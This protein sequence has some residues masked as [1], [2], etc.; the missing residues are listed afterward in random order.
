MSEGAED[1][2]AAGAV[3]LEDV[4]G[5]AGRV[6][7]VAAA[8]GGVT[9][10]GRRRGARVVLAPLVISGELVGE[11]AV[12]VRGRR[13]VE[14]DYCCWVRGA[15]RGGQIGMGWAGTQTW[16]PVSEIVIKFVPIL[17]IRILYPSG[18][19]VLHPDQKPIGIFYPVQTM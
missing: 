4:L 11:V 17:N 9:H 18:M 16:Q 6:D 19:V 12:A 2:G 14:M 10:G 5:R 8:G 15:R 7:D 3:V 1:G 13:T